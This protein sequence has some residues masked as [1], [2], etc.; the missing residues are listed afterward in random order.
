MKN[1]LWAVIAIVTGFVGFLI[2]Y[3]QQPSARGAEAPAAIAA[4]AARH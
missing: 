1:S 3:A 4:D 2:G